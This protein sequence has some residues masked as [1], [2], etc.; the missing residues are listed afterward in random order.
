MIA[1]VTDSTA[2]LGA[3]ETAVQGI[4]V[5]TLRV[6]YDGRIIEDRTPIDTA[7]VADAL[8]GGATTSRPA[9]Q[10]F[11]D[12]YGQAAAQGATGVVSVHLSGELSGTVDSALVS[13]REAPIPVEVIDSRSIAMGL[14][15][16]VLAAAQAAGRGAALA[17]VASAARRCADLTRTFFYVD[18]LEHLRRS[19]RIGAAANLV[20]SALAIKPL[21]RLGDGP[22]TV[23][24][25]VRTA[26][27]AIARLE[28]LA[29]EA[30]A[31]TPVNVAVQHLMA[32]ARA[33]ALAERLSARLPGLVRMMVVEVGPALGAHVGPGLLGVTISPV[34]G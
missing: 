2:Y 27:R 16:P 28:D 10:L 32:A 24:E 5:V 30:A 25:K 26:S 15:F 14:G 31:D 34:T 11:A 23:L 3:A 20:G 22:L 1:V 29:V 17:E 4:A 33:D 12:A 7:V 19:G 21:M 6:A 18:T 9:P 13:A 8:R